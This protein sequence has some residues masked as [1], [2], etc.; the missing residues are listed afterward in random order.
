[1]IDPAHHR[2][3]EAIL[4]IFRSWTHISSVAEMRGA[5]P[6]QICLDSLSDA[7]EMKNLVEQAERRAVRQSRGEATKTSRS[8][9]SNDEM[10]KGKRTLSNGLEDKEIQLSESGSS[11][12]GGGGRAVLTR[13][14]RSSTH[15][16]GQEH[17]RRMG[18]MPVVDQADDKEPNGRIGTGVRRQVHEE[19]GE[20]TRSL[21]SGD[22][23]GS[24]A[25]EE[26]ETWGVMLRNTIIRDLKGFGIEH[27]GPIGRSL[28]GKVM[29]VSQD[30]YPEMVRA[31]Y[32]LG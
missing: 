10:R 32:V 6:R 22:G 3:L 9:D 25:E 4:L 2:W 12:S 11:S 31:K 24:L 27:A 8:C 14:T 29:N 15:G 1:M 13:A 20:G 28:I 26:D 7:I 16:T 17:K 21:K 5:L 19:L 23:K 30:N 18:A